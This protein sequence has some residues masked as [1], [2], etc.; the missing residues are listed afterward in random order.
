MGGG[1]DAERFL[2]REMMEERA[3][4]DSGRLAEVVDRSRSKALGTD[5]V[6]RRLEKP[7][8]G[9]AALRVM[10]RRSRHEAIHTDQQVCMSSLTMPEEALLPPAGSAEVGQSVARAGVPPRGVP[11]AL[12]ELL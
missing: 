12:R 5:E 10:F 2:A 4:G 1:G 8:A 7:G 11:D 9:V 6:P 3:L